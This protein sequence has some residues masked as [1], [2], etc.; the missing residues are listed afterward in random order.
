MNKVQL[1]GTIADKKGG[2][3]KN[4]N[5][6]ARVKLRVESTYNGEVRA[7]H[8]AV[9]VFGDAANRVIGA[10][11]N[12]TMSVEGRL[13]NSKYTDADGGVHW[14]TNVVASTV[15]LR[16]PFAETVEVDAAPQEAPPPE[17]PLPD[18]IP[19]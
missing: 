13:Q 16:A 14:Q 10:A 11:E 1:A 5:A 2:T 3:S 4:G 19:F 8:F 12:S 6:W 9:A 15:Q 18:D 17:P 7:S